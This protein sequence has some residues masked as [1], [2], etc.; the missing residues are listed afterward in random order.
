M[1]VA[2]LSVLVPSWVSAAPAVNIAGPVT[3]DVTTH[4]DAVRAYWIS[5]SDCVQD[6]VLHFPLTIEEGSGAVLEV[7]AGLGAN[8]C[9]LASSRFGASALCLRVFAGPGT[10]VV[11]VADLRT[12]DLAVI[13][14]AMFDPNG[15]GVGTLAHCTPMSATTLPHTMRLYFLLIASSVDVLAATSW[16]TAIDLVAPAPPTNVMVTNLGGSLSVGWTPNVDPDVNNYEVLCDASST[17]APGCGSVD[18]APGQETTPDLVGQHF[19]GTTAAGTSRAVT[20]VLPT[21]R[22]AVSVVAIDAVGNVSR[23]SELACETL[24]PVDPPP[25][26]VITGC[27]CSVG[28]A[29]R[30]WGGLVVLGLIAACAARRRRCY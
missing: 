25:S 15:R 26:L 11:Q 13:E 20:P 19:C 10:P 29:R 12:R 14:S 2:A 28:R 22:R 18:L 5:R 27:N 21:G 23:M 16:S 30:A 4:A 17:P 3:R 6:D 7:W 1:V 9:T 24:A 8:D